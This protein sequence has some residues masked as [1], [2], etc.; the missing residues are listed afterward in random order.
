MIRVRV[1]DITDKKRV[2]NPVLICEPPQ[3]TIMRMFHNRGLSDVFNKSR[4]DLDIANI[5]QN[6]L[7]MGQPVP[8]GTYIGFTPTMPVIKD[9]IL[10]P[11]QKRD[12][13]GVYRRTIS[14]SMI[15]GL[16]IMYDRVVRFGHPNGFLLSDLFSTELDSKK[17]IA[18]F[19]KLRHW[20]FIAKCKL[21]GDL[22]DRPFTIGAWKIT[23]KGRLFVEG[24]IPVERFIYISKETSNRFLGFDD[25]GDEALTVFI[26]DIA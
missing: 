13:A 8:D 24:V 5:I 19:A 12:E 20:G 25:G 11:E 23:P 18:D 6:K 14:Y 9:I 4:L 10:T 2:P 21:D 17:L 3:S 15:V 7:D 16:K 26:S 22:S 1:R